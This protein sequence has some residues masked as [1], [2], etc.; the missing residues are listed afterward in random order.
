L[1]KRFPTL[2]FARFTGEEGVFWFIAAPFH[3]PIISI[4]AE[5]VNEKAEKM[6]REDAIFRQNDEMAGGKRTETR[7]SK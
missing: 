6:H 1:I 5:K 4:T 2:F 3:T 7:N